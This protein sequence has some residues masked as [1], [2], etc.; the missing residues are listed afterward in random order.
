MVKSITLWKHL[1]DE[2]FKDR[3][4]FNAKAN[5]GDDTKIKPANF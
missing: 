4:I 1:Y 3:N 5:N 2:K